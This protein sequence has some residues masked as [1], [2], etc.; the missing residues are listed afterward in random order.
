MELKDRGLSIHELLAM[1]EFKEANV[2][3][4]EGRLSNLIKRVNVMEVPD[5]EN[6]V[7]PG[8][9]LMTTGYPYRDNPEKF[10][11]LIP[12]L[13]EK[14]VAG[15]GIK[16]KRFLDEVPST[17]IEV[18]KQL[19]FPLMELQPDTTFSDIVR[20]VMEQVFYKESEHL[21]VLQ[22]RLQFI[23]KMLIDNQNLESILSELVKI[24]G[25]P[26]ILLDLSGEEQQLP[27]MSAN[28]K[29][30]LEQIDWQQLVGCAHDRSGVI[31]VKGIMVSVYMSH[32][33][34]KHNK[35]LWLVLLEWE[36]NT[37]SIDYLTVDR[38]SSLIALELVNNEAK[39]M[40]ETKHLDQ[41]IYDWLKG[42]IKALPDIH[43]RAESSGYTLSYGC[44]YEVLIIR[45]SDQQTDSFKLVNFIKYLKER[46]KPNS[47]VS[48]IDGQLVF[49]IHGEE[50]ED[51]NFLIDNIYRDLTIV[52][53]KEEEGFSICRG[54]QV[55]SPEKLY[56]SYEKAQSVKKI[57]DFYGFKEKVISMEALGVYR[58][59]YFLPDHNEINE[60]VDHLLGPIIDYDQKNQTNLMETLYVYFK[61]NQNMK[62]TAKALFT[63]YNTVVYRM[64]RI[65]EILQND[66]D[67][68]DIHLQLYLALKLVNLDHI[69]K[70]L[71]GFV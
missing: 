11:Q 25:N 63:H 58:L 18:A 40:V 70:S 67:N 12:I 29:E 41:F 32:I 5:V 53:G 46:A 66:L 23:T 44:F 59:L 60:Y 48:V 19:D 62:L 2:L 6:W 61:Q 21:N 52:S 42:H 9:F 4:G 30:L 28:H 50:V 16:T 65:K 27:I 64:E 43:V 34:V 38:I 22:E 57:S 56:K 1:P 26:V 10:K 36:S 37:T 71:G 45:W 20:L 55:A 14:G 51:L 13:E 68:S 49:V 17:V 31:E 54:S 47:F 24:F 7:R 8:E 15:L 35:N 39:R 3:A 69:K 33:P